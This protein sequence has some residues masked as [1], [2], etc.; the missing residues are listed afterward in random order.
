MTQAA[1][2]VPPECPRQ[3]WSQ[4]VATVTQ[5]IGAGMLDSVLE[6]LLRKVGHALPSC[7]P[8]PMT[9]SSSACL[10]PNHA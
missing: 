7:G 9:P 10:N 5:E 4:Q 3:P 6:T 1:E 8:L 2:R